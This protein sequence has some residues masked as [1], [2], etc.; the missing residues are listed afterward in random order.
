M[1]GIAGLYSLKNAVNTP[2]L[3]RMSAA[4]Q[5]RGNDSN[6][7]FIENGLGLAHQRL[8]IVDLAETGAQPMT[9]A[10][11]RFVISYN[12]E[13]YNCAVLKKLLPEVTWRG[14]SDTEILLEGLAR[15]GAATFLPKVNG[16]FAF[17]LYDKE[18]KILTLARDKFG[19]KPLY[20]MKE[21]ECFYFASEI[22]AFKAYGLD[23]EFNRDSMFSYLHYGYIPHEQQAFTGV[24]QLKAGYFLEINADLSKSLCPYFQLET[25]IRNA[26]EE[27]FN[28]N[29]EQATAMLDRL[30][31]EAVG[32]QQI[33]DVDIGAFL[34]GGIDSSLV[35]SLMQK[36]APRPVK[37]FSIGF[38]EAAFNEAPLAKQIAAHFG[39]KHHEIMMEEQDALALIPHLPS[40]YDEPF[41]DSSQIPT[42]LVS[43][44]A[45]NHVKVVM[46][47]D[48][49]DE[50]FAGYT[51]HFTAEKLFN[52]RKTPSFLRHC[53]SFGLEKMA[54]NSLTSRLLSSRIKHFDEKS[55]KLAR[56]IGAD[57][58][59]LYHHFLTPHSHEIG[60]KSGFMPSALP[61]FLQGFERVQYLDMQHYLQDDP[62]R[63]V[64]R[65]S[66]S[67]GLEVRV[68]LLDEEVVR[69]AWSLP[70]NYKVHNGQGKRIA[71]AVLNQYIPA[72]LLNQPKSGFS[73]PL[74]DWLRGGLKPLLL[75]TL[76]TSRMQNRG[77]VDTKMVKN[78]I[79]DHLSRRADNHHLLWF[80]L[81]LHLG[82]VR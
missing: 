63:K 35:T 33:A 79:E 3:E 82:D 80:I 69:F 5:G 28:G 18:T 12:G 60:L 51:R 66:M 2:A 67:T 25:L 65:A 42:L 31:S 4:L 10:N 72:S 52:L 48:G 59:S 30:L 70:A 34:S 45:S 58:Q 8:A 57:E 32:N 53:A 71:R 27:P 54:H 75:D 50:V 15:F 13:I 16:I 26:K 77:L 37:T 29:F 1:C 7:I 73:V 38:K 6:G 40:I 49:G 41:A 62:L 23:L 21:A 64:D 46:S 55:M 9:S 81:M 68:P 20:F 78:L 17:A 36:N 11:Q 76:T 56:L 47:G 61:P 22:K 39:T 74:A 43:R 44:F 24:F 14:T 19:V